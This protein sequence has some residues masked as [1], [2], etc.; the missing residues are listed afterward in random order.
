MLANDGMCIIIHLDFKAKKN[1]EGFF[2]TTAAEISFSNRLICL[3]KRS[4]HFRKNRACR[5]SVVA[6]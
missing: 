5:E 3:A 1:G 6:G 4:A 2:E